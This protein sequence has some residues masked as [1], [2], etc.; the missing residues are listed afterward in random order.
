MAKS[1]VSRLFSSSWWF[2]SISILVALVLSIMPLP[3]EFNT[4]RPDWAALVV[5]YWTIALPHKVNMG[6]AWITGF[7]LDVLLGTTLG[8]YAFSLSLIVYL[9][10]S[11]FQKI[12]NYSVWQQGVVIGIFLLLYHFIIF[13]INY[14]VLKVSFTF[15]FI[16]PAIT[17]A[18]I[19]LW[20]FPVMRGY[21][22][23][24]KVR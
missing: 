23:R 10:A 18:L 7:L 9:T 14:F 3:L 20:L 21:R 24:F 15:D 13:W 2:I 6:T 5:I 1:V 22:R 12:R 19:W 8:V 11:S 4:W 17:S 16:Y